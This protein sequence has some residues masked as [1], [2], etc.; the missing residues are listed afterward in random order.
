MNSY[1]AV[2]AKTRAMY[3]ECL[4]DKDFQNLL[5]KQ[6]V[7][8]IFLYL[9]NKGSYRR[10]FSKINEADVHRGDIEYFLQ[11]EIFDEYRR[12]LNFMDSSKSSVLRFWFARREV[13]YLKHRIRNLYNHESISHSFENAEEADD[14]FK[15]HTSIDVDLCKKATVL[16]DF[17]KACEGTVYC[18]VLKRAS[19]VN[20][21]Y[22]S[23]AMTLD[24]LYYKLLWEASKKYLLKEEQKDFSKLLGSQAD[25]LNIM[26]IYRGKRYFNFD[27]KLIYTYLLPVRYRIG[28]ELLKKLVECENAEDIPKF[29]K[30]TPY[31]NLF[32]NAG[33]GY[34]IEENYRREVYKISKKIF[35]T[36]PESVAGI[37][38][39]LDL[40]ELEIL[41]ITR[42]IECVRYNINPEMIRKHMRIS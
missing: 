20:A 36:N 6:S 42:V 14:F 5:T 39:Y 40:K 25:M 37:F 13:D 41:N 24:G 22:F 32:D 3:G 18:D 4:D 7:G 29:L 15:S 9:K 2:A 38:A 31:K 34:F 27:N 19:S 1:V 10:F 11:K 17:V 28:D 23:I 21:D 35:R 30:N 8:E 16:E 12:L 33:E 26:W